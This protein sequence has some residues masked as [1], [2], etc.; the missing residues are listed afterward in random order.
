MS[1]TRPTRRQWVESRHVQRCC[2]P[3]EYV[4]LEQSPRQVK[5]SSGT[6]ALPAS[7]TSSRIIR[8]RLSILAPPSAIVRGDESAKTRQARMVRRSR[9][10]IGE[11]LPQ[12]LAHGRPIVGA[13][14]QHQPRM[15]DRPAH[16]HIYEAVHRGARCLSVGDIPDRGAA[17][18]A[19]LT[20]RGLCP[21]L[22]RSS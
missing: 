8:W 17:N 11:N 3:S 18:T 4:N 12:R 2:L 10:Q 13:L 6:Q 16:G 21:D 9:L 15:A 5:R 7:M 20:S 14:P 19:P 22:A 1:P